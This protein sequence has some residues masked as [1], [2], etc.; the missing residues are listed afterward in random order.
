[1]N[2]WEKVKYHILWRLEYLKHHPLD[3][4]FGWMEE[5]LYKLGSGK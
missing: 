5:L 4:L 3:S 1:M 2:I